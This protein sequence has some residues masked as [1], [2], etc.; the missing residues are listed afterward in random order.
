MHTNGSDRPCCTEQQKNLRYCC[1][2]N[3]KQIIKAILLVISAALEKLVVQL[4]VA[5]ESL[6]GSFWQQSKACFGD[7][8]HN[9]K[10]L[11]CSFLPMVQCFFCS[12]LMI[13]Q[14]LMRSFFVAV[15]SL[16]CSCW[17]C[18]KACCTVF[19]KGSKLLRCYFMWRFCAERQFLKTKAFFPA[20]FMNRPRKTCQLP[21]CPVVQTYNKGAFAPFCSAP[22]FEW[23]QRTSF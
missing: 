22:L 15:K 8:C 12:F 21:L 7:F 6:L 13:A 17:Q 2:P 3:N 1:H 19:H 5:V 9:H 16:F 10:K 14:S 18:L 20:L 11:L 23:S 4:S